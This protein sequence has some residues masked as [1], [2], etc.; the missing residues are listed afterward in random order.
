MTRTRN[1]VLE[2]LAALNLGADALAKMLVNARLAHEARAEPTEVP[3]DKTTVVLGTAHAQDATTTAT[4]TSTTSRQNAPSRLPFAQC[5]AA[6][7]LLSAHV[8]LVKDFVEAEEHA[9]KNMTLQ[10]QIYEP[11]ERPCFVIC[12][13][14]PTP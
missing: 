10:F 4:T 14:T 1:D 12:T 13:S 7:T 9:L 8:N 5:Y 3:D 11:T 2:E 6:S